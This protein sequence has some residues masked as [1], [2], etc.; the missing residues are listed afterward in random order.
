[1]ILHTVNRSTLSKRSIVYTL[2]SQLYLPAGRPR[3]CHAWSLLSRLTTEPCVTSNWAGIKLSGSHVTCVLCS[4]HETLSQLRSSPVGVQTWIQR[5]PP[6]TLLDLPAHVYNA[7]SMVLTMVK[8]V[9]GDNVVMS[10]HPWHV[11]ND[12]GATGGAPLL[13]PL[14]P[15][16]EGMTAVTSK[17]F[18]YQHA[19]G[20]DRKQWR[21]LTRWCVL[22]VLSSCVLCTPGWAGGR[23][24]LETETPWCSAA[25]W[26]LQRSGA[27]R[28]DT[29]ASTPGIP[30]SLIAAHSWCWGTSRSPPATTPAQTPGPCP[31]TW[32]GAS[33]VRRSGAEEEEGDT[34][35]DWSACHDH[36][37]AWV[38]REPGQWSSGHLWCQGHKA[39][40]TR[41]PAPCTPMWRR[42]DTSF[43]TVLRN[44]RECNN[45]WVENI[46]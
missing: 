9:A 36:P 40:V 20:W 25:V 31:P 41:E 7:E 34:S 23:T 35:G 21:V 30:R 26:T 22:T 32:S 6:S 3:W 43:V 2:L 33:W 19:V 15:V 13:S 42:E 8:M 1:M 18:S 4:L 44:G 12:S 45:Q 11:L 38:S 16:T 5:L 10:T 14:S 28:L 17:G 27:F 46:S 24:S 37:P 39:L 29:S